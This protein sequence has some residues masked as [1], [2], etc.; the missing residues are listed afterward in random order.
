MNIQKILVPHDFSEHSRHALDWALALAEK[1]QASVELMH[2]VHIL[3]PVVDIPN[4]MYADVER[5][6][7]ATAQQ[8]LEAI[9]T[10][11]TSD[12]SVT[13]GIH[14]Q[15]GVPFQA[16]C[17][18]AEKQHADLI[19]MGSHGRTGLSHVF[20]GSVAERV[21][22]HAPCPVLITKHSDSA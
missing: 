12:S 17:E 21:M 15:R 11:K 10:N 18:Y 3:P 14:V 6:Q 19:V 13:I 16:I 4:D 20:L 7:L 9:H 5:D 8:H 2:V 1:W 22:R